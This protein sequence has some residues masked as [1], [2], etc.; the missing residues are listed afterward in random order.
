M[1]AHYLEI[2]TPNVDALCDT[3]AKVHGVTFSAP[4][5]GLGNARTADLSNG[6]RIGIRAPMREDE[7]PVV[8]PYLLVEDIETAVK[9]AESTGAV[10]ALPPTNVPGVGTFAIYIQGGI[11][12]GL[13][14][15]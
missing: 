7:A 14:Q 3:H 1:Q 5:T 2:V 12:H 8:R 6:G 13:W 15:V 10:I 9:N 11:D 4:N